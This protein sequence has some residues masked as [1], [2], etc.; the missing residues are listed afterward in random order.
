MEQD[1]LGEEPSDGRRRLRSLFALLLNLH[2][3]LHHH[4][5]QFVCGFRE[6][7]VQL[8]AVRKTSAGPSVLAPFS[9]LC[10]RSTHLGVAAL[11]QE[12]PGRGAH[13]QR[14]HGRCGTNF[15]IRYRRFFTPG[16]ELTAEQICC[17]SRPARHLLKHFLLRG[18]MHDQACKE[19]SRIFDERL[20]GFAI[21]RNFALCLC[22]FVPLHAR[23]SPYSSG[24]LV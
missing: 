19:P 15:R 18:D 23:K 20:Q 5:L 4:R 9:M 12:P 6:S 14:L 24:Q 21:I 11:V 3:G 17:R 7:S 16:P 1:A 22:A 8:D 13:S 10:A 2:Q